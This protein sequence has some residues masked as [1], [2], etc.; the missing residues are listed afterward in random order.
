MTNGTTYFYVITAANGNALESTPSNEANA[1]PAFVVEPPNIVF[2]IADD[3][4]TYT[5]NACRL[6]EPAETDTAGNPYPIDTPNIDRLATEEMLFHQ[7]RLMRANSGAACTRSRTCIMT[8]K[9]SWERTNGVNATTTFLGIFNTGIRTGF[10]PLPHATYRTCKNGNSYATANNEFTI[11]NDATKRGNTNSNG[12]EWHGDRALE[13]IEHWRTDHRPT[14]KPFLMY[15]GFSHPHD[16]RNSRASLTARYG[17]I[18]TTTPGTV[19]LNNAAPPL[20]YNHLPIAEATGIPSNY[21]FHPF[22]HGHLN[23]RD[24]NLAPGILQ[25]R[26]EAETRNEIGRN[27]ACVDWID[28]QIGRVFAKLE[29]SDGDGNTSDSVLDNTNIVFTSDHGIAI[30]RHGLQGKQNLYEHT[31]R[32][33]YIVRGPGIAPGSHSDALIY[34]H[35]SFPTFADLAGIDLPATIDANDG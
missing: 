21:P 12:S 32:V 2:I 22:D 17:I 16:E 11:V 35:D 3:M 25:Y 15:F 27:F 34:L 23:V 7:A 20:P 18:N 8:G 9:N 1:T 19:M 24:E 4:D 6:S 14:G 10:S 31:W 29:D 33:P 5:V 28:Q 30:G 13:H 26:N